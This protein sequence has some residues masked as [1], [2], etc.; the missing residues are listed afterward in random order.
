MK[1][2][3]NGRCAPPF[4]FVYLLD[5]RSAR[6][7]VNDKGSNLGKK[8]K[9]SYSSFIFFESSLTDVE[10]RRRDLDNLFFWARCLFFS[11]K[12]SMSSGRYP[13]AKNKTE[14]IYETHRGIS[15]CYSK[16][17]FSFSREYFTV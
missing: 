12:T 8:K 10:W 13:F 9:N 3:P 14:L 1:C 16:S 7:W 17:H 6:L 5:P 15:E 4:K 2:V 11:A